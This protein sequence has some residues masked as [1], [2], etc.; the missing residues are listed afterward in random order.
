L[1]P[2]SEVD[3]LVRFMGFSLSRMFVG[4]ETAVG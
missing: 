3:D 4:T 1:S 2:P